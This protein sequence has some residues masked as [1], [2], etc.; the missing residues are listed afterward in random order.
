MAIIACVFAG[1]MSATAATGDVG[2]RD[3]AFGPAVAAGADPNTGPTASKPQSKLWFND[4]IWWGSMLNAATGQVSIH[5]LDWQSQRWS[6]TGV[7]I[8]ERRTSHADALWDGTNLY[9]AS[10]GLNSGSINDSARFMRFS[11]NPATKQYSLDAGFPITVTTGGVEAVVVAKDT[12]GKFWVTFT[13][14]SRVFVNR[15]LANAASWGTPFILPT[16]GTTVGP[17]DLSAIIAFKS[18]IG[19]MWSNQ[20]DETMYFATHRDG[21]PDDVWG[22]SIPA[23]RGPKYADDHINLKELKSDSSGE[24]F[25]VIKTSRGDVSPNNAND[26]QIVVLALQGNALWGPAAVF[27]TV[28]ENHTRPILMIDEQNREVYVFASTNSGERPSAI[29]YKKSSLDKIAF[30][31][32]QGTPFIQ[33]ASDT[34]VNNATSTK[35]NVTNSTG[36]VVLASDLTTGY[37]AHNAVG[38]PL[39]APSPA[40]SPTSVPPTAT[41]NP[42]SPPS[43]PSAYRDAVTGTAGVVSYWRLG[44]QTGTTATDSVSGNTGTLK[45]VTL[46]SAGALSGDAN[47]AM[48]FDG[49]ASY[50]EV[51]SEANLNLSGDLTLEAW[52]KPTAVDT[53]SRSVLAKAGADGSFASRQFRLGLSEG[54]WRGTLYSTG[55][56]TFSAI[57][58]TAPVAGTWQHVVFTVSGTTLRIY[59]NGVEAGTAT[60][61]GT[62]T[63]LTS[64]TAI[65]RLGDNASQYFGGA[66][67]EVAVYNVALTTAQIQ[68]HYNAGSSAA[69]APSPTSVPPTATPSPTNVPPTATPNPTSAPPTATPSPTSVPPTATT[70]PTS[71]P[72]TATPSPTSVPPTA[73]PTVEPSPTSVPPTA[74]PSPTSVPPTATPNPTSPPPATSAYR[75]AVTGTAGVVSYWRLGEQTGTTTSDS[76]GGNTGTLTNVTLGSAG[77]LSGDANTAMTFDGKASYI[78]VP[79]TANL[80][81]SGDLTLEAWVRPT[82]LDGTS[83]TVLAKAGADGSFASRQFRF[84]LTENKWRGTLYNTGGSTF[85]AIAATVPVA[86][87]WQHV[88]FTVSGTTLRIYINGVEAGTATF[89]GTRTNVTSGTAIGRLG[90][91]PAQ[92][93]GGAIDEVAVYNVALTPAQIQQHYSLGTGTP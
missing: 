3:F 47:T 2:Y 78:A 8:D 89:S 69:P 83:R 34:N 61:S 28:Q 38:L 24:V 9:I 22:P 5:R 79:S 55:G 30:P 42:T 64:G 72:P 88:V 13:Q 80:N 37:Y 15:S 86:G 16:N 75:D 26:P 74:T 10:A 59:I 76:V 54:R 14:N 18:K 36:L 41:S 60:F 48:T 93:F 17:D 70:S 4:G 20:V 62:R 63:N 49:K 68:Q 35:Q 82:I 58:T 85:S 84:G 57:A 91:N 51:S 19:V 32:G 77:A 11:Y 33:L 56:S 90:D 12:T 52:V 87:T 6:N 44:E 92:Y 31:A 65:G 71:A 27:G 73:I 67:D 53:T 29:V 39:S 40:P 7:V 25:A 46:G 1:G 23:Y 45:S 43:S 50:I 21:D 66:I 81:L